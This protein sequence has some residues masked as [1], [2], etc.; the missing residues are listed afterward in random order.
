MKSKRWAQI[1][2]GLLL[3]TP[4]ARGSA[5]GDPVS[6]EPADLERRHDLIGRE[7][8][9]DDHVLYY[10]KREGTQ[11]DE[12]QLKR[13]RVTFLVQRALR[14]NGPG[15]IPAVIARGVLKR[16]WDRLVCE[17]NGLRAVAGDLERLQQGLAGLARTDYK[18]R[19][20]WALWAE[21]RARDFKDD[22]LLKRARALEAE[23][24]HLETM[25]Q[26]VSVDA[27][28]EWLEKAKE[29]R[30][31]KLPEPVPSALAHR[32]FRA[33]LAAASTFADLKTVMA[34]IEAF[35]PRAAADSASG[36]RNIATVEADYNANPAEAY[37]AADAAVRRA[38]DRRLWADAT[39]RLY[40]LQAQ[41][42]LKS[43]LDVAEQAKSVLPERTEL[44][45]QLVKD[46]V[47]RA[48]AKLAELR[49][50]DVKEL[51]RAYKEKLMQPELALTALREWLDLRRRRLSPTDAEGPLSLANLYE[52]L[53]ADRVTA[54]ELLRKAWK[55]DPSSKELAEALRIRGFR[56]VQDDWV[57]AKASH[58]SKPADRSSQGLRGLT[59]EEVRQKFGGPPNRVSYIATKGQMI[60]Q[61]IFVVDTKQVHFVNLLRTP[62]EPKPR[63][64]A[65]Y[66]LPRS[67]IKG[68]IGSAR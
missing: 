20:A 10:V 49:L 32:A 21:K 19:N 14:P 37:P 31:Q 5:P 35:F 57:E 18:T 62:G 45:N 30:R 54:V 52:E 68:D 11:P 58:E 65:D 56:K 22:A 26:R 41:Q 15:R 8:I 60:E 59:P 48:Q 9:V 16:Q 24:L 40:T 50:D 2:T 36:G 55:I 12:L 1:V 7:V 13:T 63:V 61:W 43:A 28:K 51:A 42:D 3:L 46:A 23:A 67:S 6:V 34:E 38:L 17:V 53:L 25:T 29:A 47:E 33:K 64:I 44:A 39:E 27:T 66:A 4:H